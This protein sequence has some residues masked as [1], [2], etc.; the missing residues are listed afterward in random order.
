LGEAR[1]LLRRLAPSCIGAT[2]EFDT[3]APTLGGIKR[4][5]A[6]FSLDE[7]FSLPLSADPS[8][9]FEI[10]LNNIENDLESLQAFLC[11]FT[12]GRI[13]ELEKLI[14]TAH[15]GTPIDYAFIFRCEAE[16]SS[17][18]DQKMKADVNRFRCFD[19]LHAEKIT[20]TFCKLAK[21][22]DAGCFL[23]SVRDSNG[24][25]FASIDAQKEYIVS[26]Y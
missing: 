15:S 26:Y 14:E 20:P 25:E 1:V 5:L 23:T 6:S 7:C 11:K 12:F 18:A 4:I 16:L 13:K 24:V 19:N 9:F 21:T 2:S 8:V 17:I 22:G 10:L 3:D